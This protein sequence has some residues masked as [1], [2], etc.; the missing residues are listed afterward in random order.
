MNRHGSMAS[1]FCIQQGNENS[2]ATGLPG[3]QQ[4]IPLSREKNMIGEEGFFLFVKH[5]WPF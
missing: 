1:D 4:E 5:V 2:G 3:H